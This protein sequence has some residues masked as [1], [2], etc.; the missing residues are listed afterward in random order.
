M[1]MAEVTG[2][3]GIL[4]LEIFDVGGGHDGTGCD[5]MGRDK[6]TVDSAV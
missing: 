6:G 5:A 1:A 3:L 4:L 2:V